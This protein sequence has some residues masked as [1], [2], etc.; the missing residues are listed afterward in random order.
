M[1]EDSQR[2]AEPLCIKQFWSKS[3]FASGCLQV[4]PEGRSPLLPQPCQPLRRTFFACLGH[5]QV[6]HGLG[7]TCAETLW[8]SRASEGH[9]STQLPLWDLARGIMCIS[10]QQISFLA[11]E[12]HYYVQSGDGRSCSSQVC[13]Y[14]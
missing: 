5:S 8:R 4:P 12:Y 3:P 6:V 7:I 14:F 10:C 9:V 11:D 1:A 13:L 2:P